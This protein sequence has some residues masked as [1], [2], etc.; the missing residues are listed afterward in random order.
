MRAL[1]YGAPGARKHRCTQSREGWL[2]QELSLQPSLRG[3]P[4]A[5]KPPSS[6]AAG[7]QPRSTKR[8][9]LCLELFGL[10]PGSCLG[11]PTVHSRGRLTRLWYIR[12]ATYL[13]VDVVAAFSFGSAFLKQLDPSSVSCDCWL[14]RPPFASCPAWSSAETSIHHTNLRVAHCISRSLWVRR[15]RLA[16]M[17]THCAEPGEA[18]AAGSLSGAG[19]NEEAQV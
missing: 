2:L 1:N 17:P 14:R 16:K 19:P 10:F 12:A 8:T 18:H 4:T 11:E 6:R 9:V 15:L 7:S 3:S 5:S 13:G